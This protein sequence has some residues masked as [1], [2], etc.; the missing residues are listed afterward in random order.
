MSDQ[1]IKIRSQFPEALSFLFERTRYK[2]A[3]GGRGGGKSWAFARSLL[4]QGMQTPL[5]ILCTRETQKS[6]ADSVHT[7]LS[8]N[9]NRLGIGAAYSVQKG[10]I[11]GPWGIGQDGKTRCQTEFIFAGLR[12][13]VHN[14]KSIEACD[15]VWVEEAQT[16]SKDSWDTLIPTL[17]GG[18]SLEHSEIWVTFNPRMAKDETYKRFVLNTP[19]NSVAR[20]ITWRDNPW[21]PDDLR[22][23]R[24]Y[25]REHDYQA[26]LNVYEGEPASTEGAVYASE[27]G[28]V[29]AEKRI[30]SVPVDRMRPVD[31]FWDLGYGDATAIW[32]AQAMDSG[33]IRVIDYL[34]GRSRTMESYVA[35]LQNRG[36][37]Y[38]TDWLPHDGVDAI[39]HRRLS[40]DR[41]R[42]PEMILRNTGR[43]VR[44][45]PKL[46]IGSGINAVRST[47]PNCWFD[48]DKCAEG[49]S[50]LRGYH[51]A[52]DTPGGTERNAPVHDWASHGADA[53]RTLA[54]SI[55]YPEKR[56]LPRE[57]G[58]F[59][60]NNSKNQA[61]WMGL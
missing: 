55:K 42:S 19:P 35:E 54:V 14:I 50:A 18:L 59:S 13:N 34:E 39:I 29:E 15:I 40:G 23:E 12:H 21:F 43:N 11:L 32:F 31:T 60:G 10:T 8:D 36:Y 58:G 20:K 27:M 7:L 28:E 47:L 4:I 37:M 38:G 57:P 56:E 51:W 26:Y 24:E 41:S 5:R 61:S 16:V 53:F 44:I 3:Y 46:L 9:I 6:I 2:I 48:A 25:M 45:S 17:R 33:Q 22:I 30:T 49:L 52:P 1:T